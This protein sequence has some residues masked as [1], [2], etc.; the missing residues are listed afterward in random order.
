[1][2]PSL[3]VTILHCLM[4]SVL[5]ANFSFILC[6]LSGEGGINPGTPSWL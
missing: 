4:S 1:L 2:F 3:R 5:K 6:V